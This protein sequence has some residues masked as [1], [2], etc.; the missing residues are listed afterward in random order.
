MAG[1]VAST[2]KGGFVE[3][4]GSVGLRPFRMRRVSAHAQTR[5]EPWVLVSHTQRIGHG[6]LVAP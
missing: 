5:D 2:V 3:R 6:T 4:G 1:R